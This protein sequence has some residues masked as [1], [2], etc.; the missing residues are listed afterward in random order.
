M[1]WQEAFTPPFSLSD[2]YIF[3]SK[4]RVCLNTYLDSPEQRVKLLNK[5]NGNFDKKPNGIFS[6]SDDKQRV[7]FEDKPVLL[8]RG[9]GRLTGVGGLNLSDEDAIS[10]QDQFAE[11]IVK[12]LNS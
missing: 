10:L 1:N 8:I 4:N 6:L 2:N 7:L 11:W 12:T 5:L 3:D 9:W